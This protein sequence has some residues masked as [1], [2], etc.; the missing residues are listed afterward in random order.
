MIFYINRYFI[1]EVSKEGGKIT[2]LSI[3]VYH[4]KNNHKPAD[5]FLLYFYWYQKK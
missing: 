2:I 3:T 4:I 1:H 5:S